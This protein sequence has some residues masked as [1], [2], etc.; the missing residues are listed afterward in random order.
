V[1]LAAAFQEEVMKYLANKFEKFSDDFLDFDKVENKRATAPDLHAF[2]LLLELVP[3]DGDIVC[4]AEH[5]EIFLATDC[6]KLAEVA[7]DEHIQELA[8]CGV[9]YDSEFDCLAMF[10]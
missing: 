2:L 10:V 1:A 4:A 7:K 3:S 9:R 6:E 5:D 8:R